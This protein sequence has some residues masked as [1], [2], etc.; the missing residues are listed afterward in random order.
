MHLPGT[1]A[2]ESRATDDEQRSDD[3]QRW[4][5]VEDSLERANPVSCVSARRPGA[6]TAL[7]RVRVTRAR[8][9]GEAGPTNP[10]ATNLFAGWRR[11][12][13]LGRDVSG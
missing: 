7:E 11:R 1:S 3:Y 5:H 9:A 6:E 8:P 12:G 13:L 10:S 4:R 2:H